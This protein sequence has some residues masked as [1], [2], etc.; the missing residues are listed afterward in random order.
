MT[1]FVGFPKIA[2]FRRDITITEKIDGTNAQVLIKP[3]RLPGDTIIAYPLVI[4]EIDGVEYAVYAGCRTRW[5]YPN[6]DSQNQDNHGFAAWVFEHAEDL[7]SVLGEGSHFGEWWG[8][9]INRGYGMKKKVFSLFNT[10][11]WSEYKEDLESFGAS[12]VPNLYQGPYIDPQQYID[13]LVNT[14]SVAA[15]GYDNPEGIVI[16]F[17]AARTMFKQTIYKDDEWKGKQE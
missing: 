13:M 8:Q 4:R 5:I 14:G 2:R 17:H 11:R 1:E 3:I 7:I 10:I 9:G 15:P 6:S 12:V 16:Y